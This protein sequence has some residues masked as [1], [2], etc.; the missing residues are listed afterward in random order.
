MPV[1]VQSTV[2]CRNEPRFS[3]RWS[4]L[5]IANHAPLLRYS[6]IWVDLHYSPG[7]SALVSLL[8]GDDGLFHP[9][10]NE[11]E[12]PSV[13]S[14]MTSVPRSPSRPCSPHQFSHSL[15]M[16]CH[17]SGITFTSDTPCRTLRELTESQPAHLPRSKKSIRE[18]NVIFFSIR[19]RH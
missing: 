18:R 6:Q 15:P 4:R 14:R 1:Q 7:N 11:I 13:P 9:H 10:A 3:S 5:S 12:S 19:L 2:F 8:P 16:P 17:V